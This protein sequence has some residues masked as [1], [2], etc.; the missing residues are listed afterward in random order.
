MDPVGPRSEWPCM[1]WNLR[2]RCSWVLSITGE[3]PIM[4]SSALMSHYARQRVMWQR[5][6]RSGEA[7]RSRFISSY[8]TTPLE[9]TVRER[10]QTLLSSQEINSYYISF[11]EA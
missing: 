7:K 2:D 3:N 9:Q 4:V 8:L 10:C 5:E 11:S 1:G 6:P